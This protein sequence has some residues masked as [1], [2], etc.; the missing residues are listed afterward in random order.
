[1]LTWDRIDQLV[2]FNANGARILSVYL[3]LGPSR[4]SPRVH[5]RTFAE[6]VLQASA[7]LSG[8]DRAALLREARS[9]QSWLAASDPQGVA[10]VIFSCA[11]EGLWQRDFIDVPLPNRLT[12]G[13]RTD[14]TP[15]LDVFEEV[16]NALRD[17]VPRMLS[18]RLAAIMEGGAVA[19]DVEQ[20]ARA[21]EVV[22]RVEF[23]VE[24]GRLAN[25][26]DARVAQ[27]RRSIRARAE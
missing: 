26:L 5:L 8:E 6:L 24:A 23:A 13:M 15:L 10:L 19:S 27:F 7:R 4:M 2:A 11:S 17:V 21:L 14:I 18:D 12:Y 1:M 16:S 3:D 20:L 22:R 25:T 9:V